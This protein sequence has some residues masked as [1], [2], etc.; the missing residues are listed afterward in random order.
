MTTVKEAVRA[1]LDFPLRKV[2]NEKTSPFVK[3]LN[4]MLIGGLTVGS[5][6]AYGFYAHH[7]FKTKKTQIADPQDSKNQKVTK[8]SA[9]V[10]DKGKKDLT[11]LLKAE[12]TLTESLVEQLSL[13]D[14]K[15]TNLYTFNKLTPDQRAFA[16]NAII[17]YHDLYEEIKKDK[18]EK[19]KNEAT[20][21]TPY[22]KAKF[23]L[24]P[25]VL[26]FELKKASFPE[27][28]FGKKGDILH[29]IEN[30]SYGH[31]L[32]THPD[33][34]GVAIHRKHQSQLCYLVPKSIDLRKGQI[35]KE[36]LEGMYPLTTLT[37]GNK[38]GLLFQKNK[39][40]KYPLH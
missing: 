23:A 19:G 26:S 14:D 33:I 28:E 27:I 6:S 12:T 20:Y 17:S 35:E 4:K 15:A 2:S 34:L 32:R 7:Y 37:G 36:F 1:I 3:F 30:L 5:L 22:L 40:K 11:A 13:P 18:K 29:L 10:L 39:F 25:D 16:R 8:A 31:M 38:W 24:H 9:K 21:E